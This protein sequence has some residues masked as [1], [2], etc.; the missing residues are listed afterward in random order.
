MSRQRLRD[1]ARK[2]ALPVVLGGALLTLV[3]AVSCVAAIADP[4]GPIAAGLPIAP[5]DEL[6]A[7][8][9]LSPGQH[10]SAAQIR[11]GKAAA[12]SALAQ[13]PTRAT[14]WLDLAYAESLQTGALN[15]RARQALSR[16]WVFEPLGPD[17]SEW[18]VR[19]VFEHWSELTPD[20][21]DSAA[22]EVRAQ[23]PTG[24]HNSMAKA[25]AEVKD[26]AG[27]LAASLLRSELEHRRAGK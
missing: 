1:A 2:L 12:E 11:A 21:R 23:W 18:R 13:G 8:R 26:P 10:L 7:Q 20:L 17:D 9:L 5:A 25:L 27:Q 16:S 24:M 4:A 6:R 14:A 19:F 15:D 3:A 22:A